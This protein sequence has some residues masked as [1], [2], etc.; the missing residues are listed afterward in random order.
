M[1][2]MKRSGKP[3]KCGKIVASILGYTVNPQCPK[4][5]RAA[6]MQDGSIVNLDRLKWWL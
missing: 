6:L 5:S 4:Q 2:V 3:F 1:L